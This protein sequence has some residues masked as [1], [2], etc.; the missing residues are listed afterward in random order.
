VS[1]QRLSICTM[2]GSAACTWASDCHSPMKQKVR[3]PVRTSA[4]RRKPGK[5]ARALRWISMSSCSRPGLARNRTTLHACVGPPVMRPAQAS[6][7][8]DYGG[9][10][11][12]ACPARQ[13]ASRRRIHRL[14]VKPVAAAGIP[15]HA[16]RRTRHYEPAIVMRS[17][18]TEPVRVLLRV[19][20]SLPT[21]TMPMNM[22]RRLP[23]TVISSTGYWISPCSTQK[24]AAPR[25]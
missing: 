24:P 5:P 1:R 19:S 12:A 2:P 9:Y 14:T 6:I 7:D 20:T 25:E 3:S 21:S 17:I 16:H 18:N 23:A 10:G 4:P 8:A 15:V 22:S 11:T 13:V